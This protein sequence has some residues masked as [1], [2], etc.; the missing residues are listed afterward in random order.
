MH[1]VIK[2]L[3]FTI[4]EVGS[5]TVTPSGPAA[6]IESRQ[7]L[8]I[9]VGGHVDHGKST[10][11]GRLLADTASLPQGKLEQV[12]ALCARTSKPFEY[13]FLIDALREERAQGITIDS[14]R[15]FFRTER[16]DYL[17]I[18]APGHIEFLKNMVTGASRAEAA[19]LVID[20]K[21]G[22]RENS[23]R[24]GY[25]MAMLGVRQ[26][27]VVVNKMDLVGYDAEAFARLEAEYRAFLEQIQVHPTCFI[28]VA[29]RLGDN[30]ARRS[31]TMDWY[32][33][34]TVLEALD[35]FA[36]GRADV[37]A[38]FRM[39]VQDV[40]KFTGDGDDRRIVAGTVECGAA[41][42][43]DEVVFYPSGK[44]GTIKSV[45][46]FGREWPL[47]E[48]AAGQAVGFTLTDEIYVTRGD[49]ATLARQP[50]P[51]VTTRLRVS[52]FWLGQQPLV[53]G[54]DYL[55]RLGTARVRMRVDE[56]HRVIDASDLSSSTA[57][58]QVG[59]N[60]V[61]ECTILLNRAIAT[62]VATEISATSRFVIVDDFEIRGGGIVRD[63]L[64][65]DQAAVREKVLL[66]N[67][68]W[69]SSSIP[70]QRR[71]VRL[72]QRPALVLITG[73]QETN[74][75]ALARELEVSL[76]EEGRAVYFLGI[77]NVLYG[78]DA[79]LSRNRTNRHEH[80]RRLAE[81]ANLML[82][83]GT[84]LI[85]TAL[86]LSAE[87]LDLIGT[88]VEPDLIQTV[89][90]GQRAAAGPSPDL[91]LTEQESGERGVERITRL[92]QDKG[93]IFRPC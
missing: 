17:V 19:L 74:R 10:I 57:R 39:P 81:V 83:A 38:P 26:L 44:K 34:P 69:E 50:R 35:G 36:A 11:I 82:D 59:R 60:E 30:I 28:P 87:D 63:A 29:G 45:E 33:G 53:T 56:V 16:R 41:S 76:F 21:E 65:D 27:A 20:A 43:G 40:Y 3:S 70:R 1:E 73:N 66:R 89:W 93:I 14:A 22:V 23:K 49:I 54:K 8:T 12:R 61:A 79:D 51:C 4:R 77:A 32:T 85:V 47:E 46:A 78:V 42:V 52:I 24:H 13:A 48:A 5:A 62:D 55:F 91:V 92:L 15:I 58:R 37:E 75:K 9:V 31:D 25:M 80:I 84:I 7:R 72:A 2:P 18:D 71:A 90:V 86:E 64:P 67:A 6:S 68:K 88:T